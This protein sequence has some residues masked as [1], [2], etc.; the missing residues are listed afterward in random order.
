MAKIENWREIPIEYKNYVTDNSGKVIFG[1]EILGLVFGK[2][3]PIAT[4][5]REKGLEDSGSIRIINNGTSILI[6][7]VYP[8]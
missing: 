4:I 5:K 2:E 8:C 7:R 6:G 3:F 1:I